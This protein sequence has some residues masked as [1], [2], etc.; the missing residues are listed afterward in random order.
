M[1]SSQDADTNTKEVSFHSTFALYY[2]CCLKS[3]PVH[4]ST[5]KRRESWGKENILGTPSTLSAH[6]TVLLGARQNSRGSHNWSVGCI[7]SWA[8]TWLCDIDSALVQGEFSLGVSC[9]PTGSPRE[10][11]INHQRTCRE[12]ETEWDSSSDPHLHL[13]LEVRESCK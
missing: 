6:R 2:I 10:R 4:K 5:A 1:N 13:L 9:F 12:L 7:W 11:E 3:L 8:T